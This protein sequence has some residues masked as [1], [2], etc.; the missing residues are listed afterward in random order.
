MSRSKT[1]FMETTEIAPEKSAAEITRLLVVSGARQISMQYAGGQLSG[2]SFV[3]GSGLQEM[4]FSLPVRVEPVFQL[5]NSRRTNREV[6]AEKDW[7]QAERVAWRQL[8]RWVQAQLALVDTGMVQAGEV[9]MPYILASNGRTMWDEFSRT[10][11]LG[12]ST[13]AS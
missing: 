8:L 7:L 1:L 4:F 10:K 5:L 3:L 9:F 2:L 11:L 6:S 12:A 13:E